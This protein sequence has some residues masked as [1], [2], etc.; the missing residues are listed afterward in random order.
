MRR[1]QAARKQRRHRG[2]GPGLNQ[3]TSRQGHYWISLVPTGL[4]NARNPV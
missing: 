3:V 4:R 2:T 1:R